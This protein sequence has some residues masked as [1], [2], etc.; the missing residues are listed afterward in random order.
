MADITHTFRLPR[1]QQ[2]ELTEAEAI[3]LRDA[4]NRLYPPPS[5]LAPLVAPLPHQPATLWPPTWGDPST[6]TLTGDPLPNR[7]TTT[8]DG[9]NAAAA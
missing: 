9:A 7:L 6:G 3:E 1:G 2:A 4:L 5:V 8:C